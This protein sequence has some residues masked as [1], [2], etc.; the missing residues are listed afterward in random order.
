MGSRLKPQSETVVYFPPFNTSSRKVHP[1]GGSGR[2]RQN[3]FAVKVYIF[4]EEEEL[5]SSFNPD[6]LKRAMKKIKEDWKLASKDTEQKV[7]ARMPLLNLSLI[8]CWQQKLYC[9]SP[10]LAVHF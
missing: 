4:R 5:R 8:T 9:V 3:G 1:V 2:K 7:V 10:L 6:E